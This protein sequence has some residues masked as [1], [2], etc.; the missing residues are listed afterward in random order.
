MKFRLEGAEFHADVEID[1]QTD[2]KPVVAFRNS[3]N[4]LKT[5]QRR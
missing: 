3:A 4:A 2:M 5:G 1:G